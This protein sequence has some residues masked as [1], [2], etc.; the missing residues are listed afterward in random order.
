VSPKHANY[1]VN[2]GAATAADV[3][4]VIAQVREMVRE[5]FGARLG[6]EVKVIGADG[7]IVP[8]QA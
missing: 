2:T 5:R 3:L 4:A 6:L 7:R 1:I 8:D